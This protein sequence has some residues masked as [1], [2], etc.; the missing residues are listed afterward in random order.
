VTTRRYVVRGRVQG[1]GFR[2]FVSREA[3]RLG[4]RGFAR[5]LVD[6]SVEVV[7][8]G[9]DESLQSLEQALEKGPSYARVS[10]VEKTDVPHDMQ[11]PSSF[12]TR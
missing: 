12:E 3:D 9:S 6:G 5:N 1:V 4:V 8:Q 10:G 11:L 2:W 7:A